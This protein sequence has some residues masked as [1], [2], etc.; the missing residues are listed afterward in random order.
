MTQAMYNLPDLIQSIPDYPV[1]GM[2]YRDITPLLHHPEAFRQVVDTFA[3]HYR[4][5]AI[6]AVVGI[7]SRGFIF[8]A[9]LAYQLGVSLVPVRKFGKIPA[10]AYEVEYYLHFGPDKLQLHRDA[11]KPGQRV[12]VCDDLIATGSTVAAACELVAMAGAEVAEVACLIELGGAPGHE[13][14]ASY[15]IFSLIQL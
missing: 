15:P 8:S 2:V 10:P 5:L 3:K 7:E 11:L 1:E 9:P 14:L 12:I 4:G 6:D 13:Q